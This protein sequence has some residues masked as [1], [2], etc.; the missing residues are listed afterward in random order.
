MFREKLLHIETFFH[1]FFRINVCETEFLS[2]EIAEK[3]YFYC[4][5]LVKSMPIAF[6]KFDFKCYFLS[7]CLVF[8]IFLVNVHKID[9]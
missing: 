3:A 1:A 2:Y 8:P 7:L 4:E 5:K 9:F 6:E